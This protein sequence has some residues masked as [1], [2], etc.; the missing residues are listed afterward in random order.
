MGPNPIACFHARPRIVELPDGSLLAVFL[1]PAASDQ[2]AEPS[3]VTSRRST[4]GGDTWQ[5]EE[6]LITLPPAGRLWYGPDALVDDRGELHVFLLNDSAG[7]IGGGEAHRPRAGDAPRRELNIW[8]A[9]TR[10]ERAAWGRLRC[11][12]RGYTG[13]LNSVIQL[14]TGRIILP[15]SSLTS[16][17]W[18]QRGGGL[19]EFTC[20]GPFDS[21]VLYSDD[22]GSTWR[23]ARVALQVPVPDIV[24]AYGAVEPVAVERRDGRVWMLIRTQM[25][26]FYECLSDDGIRWSRPAPSA[27]TSSDSPA[28]LVAL[29]DG[30]LVLVWNNCQRHPYAYGGRHVLHAA[31]SDDDGR[32]WRGYREVARDPLRDQPPPPSGDHG[33]A[34]PFPAATRDGR[35][36]ISTGQGTERER[37]MV[38]RL[39]PDWLLE[40][41]Q[42]DD[43]SGGLDAW[44]VFG[45][46][47]VALAR[48]PGRRSAN[49]LS[50]G[51]A[52]AE[53]PAAAVWNF[54]CGPRG[55]ITLQL[56]AASG[57]GGARVGLTDHFSPPFDLEDHFHN[58]CTLR[59]APGAARYGAHFRLT[60]GAWH[61]L[62]IAWNVATMRFRAML[63]GRSL[64]RGMLSRQSPGPCYLRLCADD[65]PGRGR[66]LVRRVEAD[67]TSAGGLC[68]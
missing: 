44:S 59:L 64:T 58:L 62:R 25:G 13:A 68:P 57:F 37:I 7:E 33:T 6:T 54:P 12:W 14:R 45:T 15:F 40:T 41:R 56:R 63:D 11:I 67:I 16:R 30:R 24:S 19:N 28:G 60:G 39:D 23:Q 32:T 20:V 31:I 1:R 49:V 4:D 46:R 22:R 3:R 21:T 52:D 10:S 27:I 47:G 55:H 50:I 51:R 5:P 2:P 43:F 9:R 48:A 66:L 42:S 17:N 35:V 65:P 36:I 29:P 18:R 26:R 53:W 34:Y 38:V 61:E 8:H